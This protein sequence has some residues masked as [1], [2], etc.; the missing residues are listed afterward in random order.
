MKKLFRERKFVD[1][2]KLKMKIKRCRRNRRKEF[3]ADGLK[4]QESWKEDTESVRLT[5][6]K[7]DPKLDNFECKWK[8]NMC[9]FLFVNG[10][11]SY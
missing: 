2:E 11:S 4:L 3:Y 6:L 1:L 8:K 5:M 10:L 9:I 7:S